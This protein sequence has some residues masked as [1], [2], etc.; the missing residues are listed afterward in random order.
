MQAVQDNDMAVSTEKAGKFKPQPVKRCI[1]CGATG[2]LTNEHMWPRWMHPHLMRGSAPHRAIRTTVNMD[3]TDTSN[4]FK[5]VG[6]AIDWQV[7][8]VCAHCNGGWMSNRVEQLVKPI[9]IPLFE[10][11]TARLWPADQEKIAAWAVMKYMVA[12]SQDGSR[13]ATAHHAQ[14]RRMWRKQLPPL[15]GWGVWV[16]MKDRIDPNLPLSWGS[17]AFPALSPKQAKKRVSKGTPHR[18]SDAAT[19]VVGKLFFHVIHS[20]ATNLVRDFSFNLP[21]GGVLCRI[22][23]PTNASIVWPPHG[24]SDLDALTASNAMRN[25]VLRVGSRQPF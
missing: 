16:G 23:P 11:Q 9:M 15:H 6:D 5:K 13:K 10:N 12:D 14:R 25:H 7:S 19:Q 24:M 17:T 2:P 3:G 18:N 20:P 4:V 21:N 1:F 22:W 8:C